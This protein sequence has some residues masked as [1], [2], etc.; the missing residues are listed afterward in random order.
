[1]I[2]CNIIFLNYNYIT[3]LRFLN[4][5]FYQNIKIKLK[6]IS[7]KKIFYLIYYYDIFLNKNL[8]F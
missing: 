1:M 7:N 8:K 2:D 5:N 6:N 3:E 4:I